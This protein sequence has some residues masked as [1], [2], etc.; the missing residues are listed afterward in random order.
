MYNSLLCHT[1]FFVC[2]LLCHCYL[3]P[4]CFQFGYNSKSL[5][6]CMLVLFLCIAVLWHIKHAN[7]TSH[8]KMVLLA[9]LLLRLI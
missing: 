3:N 7:C 6:A 9:L 2:S 4:C 5:L 8:Y 1:D